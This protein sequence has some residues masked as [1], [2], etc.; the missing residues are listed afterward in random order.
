MVCDKCSVDTSGRWVILR[1]NYAGVHFGRLVSG[2]G[3]RSVTLTD[4]RRI[5]GWSGA[6]TLSEAATLGIAANSKVSVEVSRI[7]VHDVHEQIDCSP[8]AVASIR[9]AQ[10]Q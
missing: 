10:W 2:D 4:S 8:V 9:T 7:T 1:S 6:R 3:E 5:W